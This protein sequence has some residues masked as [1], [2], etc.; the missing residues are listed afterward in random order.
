LLGQSGLQLA[1]LERGHVAVDP[2]AQRRRSGLK[3][4][5]LGGALGGALGLSGAAHGLS[6]VAAG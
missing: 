4:L 2:S 5:A 6:F 3:A 1:S